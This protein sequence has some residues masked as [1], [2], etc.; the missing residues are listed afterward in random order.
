MNQT[1]ESGETTND[2]KFAFRGG[3]L[4]LDLV[5]TEI[6]ERGK[7][8]DLLLTPQDLR[9]WWAEARPQ[10]G[11]LALE[12]FGELEITDDLL[13][14]AKT[15]RS[16]LRTL[17][18]TIVQGQSVSEKDLDSLN[19]ILATG[20]QAIR[21]IANEK[22]GGVY[23]LNTQKPEANPVLLEVALSAYRLLTTQDLNRL[24]KCKSDRCV[25]YFYDTTKSATR[26]WCS[27]G[28][29][30]RARSIQHYQQTKKRMKIQE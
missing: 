25:L 17:F 20:H 1:E 23:R 11:V 13:E 4:A 10:T 2:S 24:H 15:L 30:N 16:S 28:C 8:Q 7:P 9:D 22:L 12:S 27:L 18:A 6:M 21:S 5:N 29:M 3:P 26:H 19:M 14:A